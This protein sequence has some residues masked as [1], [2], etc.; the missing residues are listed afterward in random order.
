MAAPGGY[1]LAEH[2]NSKDT[3]NMLEDSKWD[4]VVLQEQSQIPSIE[5]SRNQEMYPAARSL[6]RSIEAAGAKPIFFIT[7]AHQ[8][9]WPENNLQ[10]YK[11]M[12]A[13]INAGYLGIAQELGVSLAPVG[14]A[15]ATV[16]DEYPQLALWQGDG[17]HPTQEGTYLA[18]C[19]FYAVIFHQSPE[20]LTFTAGLPGADVRNIQ[21]LA[22]A[23]VLNN[24]QEWN[25][26]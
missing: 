22:S 4:F 6:V 24:S 14:F 17:S 9:G 7:W 3:L 8:D 21:A 25:L 11:S 26:P 23:T 10:D 5:Q 1:T 15:W 19:V 2:V 18:A 13:Q 20:G 16:R 12:Q